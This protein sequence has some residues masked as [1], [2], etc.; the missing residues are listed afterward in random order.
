M[1]RSILSSF[2]ATLVL[3][4]KCTIILDLVQMLIRPCISYSTTQ[5][6]WDINAINAGAHKNKDIY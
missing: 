6:L 2:L 3:V 4:K 5:G 1:A